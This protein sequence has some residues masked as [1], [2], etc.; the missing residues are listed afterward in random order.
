M[1]D[2]LQFNPLRRRRRRGLATRITL[3]GKGDWHVLVRHRLEGLGPFAHL[4]PVLFM[5]GGDVQ[6]PSV[7]TATGAFEPL[8]FLPPS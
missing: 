2:H 8:R 7:S 1:L 4:R 6:C 5:G 3:I